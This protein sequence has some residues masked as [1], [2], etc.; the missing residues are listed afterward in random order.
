MSTGKLIAII[1]G[2]VGMVIVL[3]VI[4]VGFLV[5]YLQTLPQGSDVVETS[6]G[7]STAKTSGGDWLISVTSGSATS[8][9]VT[10]L[11]TDP[12]TGATIVSSRLTSIN[13]A[14]GTYNDNNGNNKVDAGDTVLLRNT[15][16]VN[17]GM[18]VQFLKGESV[19]G[20][21]RELPA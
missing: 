19:I 20:T 21:I 4:L 18:K 11:V 3:P 2:V 15:A 17:P 10:V 13:A 16:S 1:A 9:S 5:L 8:S 14:D 12:N 7:L 6:L